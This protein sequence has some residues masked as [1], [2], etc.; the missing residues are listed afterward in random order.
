MRLS[1][2]GCSFNLSAEDNAGGLTLSVPRLS[3]ALIL[4]VRQR[5]RKP[6]KP[7]R[8]Q[9]STRCLA[10]QTEIANILTPSLRS[11]LSIP[12]TRALASL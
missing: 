5:I 7:R 11:A 3:L 10:D 4:L 9:L 8:Q 2:Q 12:C 1:L 6:N